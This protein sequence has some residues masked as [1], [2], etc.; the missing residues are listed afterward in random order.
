MNYM[1]LSDTLLKYWVG[2]FVPIGMWINKKRKEYQSV[3]GKLD[4]YA[5]KVDTLEKRV[6]TMDNK[7]D[8]RFDEVCDKLDTYS[9]NVNALTK[10]LYE[11]KEETSINKI[12]LEERS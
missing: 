10:A 1:E 9:D 4:A 8:K 2:I 3:V 11:V 7:F 6:D 5:A 12:R